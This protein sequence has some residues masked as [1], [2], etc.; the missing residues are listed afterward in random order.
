M[1]HNQEAEVTPASQAIIP[2]NAS[3]VIHRGTN[4]IVN[5]STSSITLSSPNIRTTIREAI[6]IRDRTTR[7]LTSCPSNKQGWPVSTSSRRQR[8]FPLW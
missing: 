6:S 3:M 5:I 8:M 1:D 2:S 7:S 4:N